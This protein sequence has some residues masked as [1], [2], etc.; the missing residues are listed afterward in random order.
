MRL[1]FPY[2]VV[3][4]LN[5]KI[6]SMKQRLT[7][8]KGKKQRRSYLGFC[9]NWLSQVYIYTNKRQRIP[10]DQSKMENPAKL[11]TQGT[12]DEENQ[13]KNTTQYVYQYT[14]WT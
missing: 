4:I 2:I 11:A 1:E 12:K 10:K 3:F 6:V 5:G 8:D 13:N 14:T 9:I 7:K